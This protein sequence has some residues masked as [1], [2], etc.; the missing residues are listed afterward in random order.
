MERCN[1]C[2]RLSD[3]DVGDLLCLLGAIFRFRTRCGTK[4]KPRRL[5]SGNDSEHVDSSR[6]IPGPRA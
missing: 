3:E 1:P 6:A 4:Q 5:E 2:L